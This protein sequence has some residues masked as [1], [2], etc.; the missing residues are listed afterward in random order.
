[1]SVRSIL[2]IGKFYPPHSGGMETHVRDLALRQSKSAQVSVIVANSTAHDETSCIDGVHVTRVAR[3]ATIASMPVCP[4]LVRAIRSAPADIVHIHVPNP[5]A[6]LAFL[7]SGHPGKLVI[8]HHADTLGRPFLRRLS[9]PFVHALMRRSSRILVTSHRYLASSPEL[10]PFGEKC[11]VI[12][13]GIDLESADPPDPQQVAHIRDRFGSRLIL[14]IGRLV[15]YKGFDVL[16]RAMK[17][18]DA[19]LVVI[20]TGPQHEALTQLVA[21]QALQDRVTLLGRVDNISPYLAASSLFVLPSVTRAEAFGIVQLEAM[22]AGLPVI[23]T[24]I[25][26]GVPEVGVDQESAV[27]V[28]PSDPVALAVAMQRLLDRDDLRARL[29]KAGRLKV[30]AEYTNDRMAERTLAV[31][32][33][34]LSDGPATHSPHR[35]VESME[36]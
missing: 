24:D 21:S 5:G 28:P 35:T 32:D 14:A 17:Q 22:A 6:A 25:D 31:Y 8:T 10:A 12:P 26:S 7:L 33:Q 30:L 4:G 15:P 27:T 18:V 2:H 1:M 13:L 19:R 9:D 34:V 23:N 20:G 36:R 11:S 3:F 29:G 16:I